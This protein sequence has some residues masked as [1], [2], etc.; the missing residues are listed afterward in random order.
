MLDNESANIESN[1]LYFFN[2]TE[3]T[4]KK[5]LIEQ[6]VLKASGLVGELFD[7]FHAI[8]YEKENIHVSPEDKKRLKDQYV[9]HSL[10]GHI[11]NTQKNFQTEWTR[12]ANVIG[13]VDGL[14][15]ASAVMFYLFPDNWKYEASNMS[16]DFYVT[17]EFIANICYPL[18]LGYIAYQANKTAQLNAYKEKY[19]VTDAQIPQEVRDRIETESK[20]LGLKVMAA[21]AGWT[22]GYEVAAKIWMSFN[23]QWLVFADA[24]GSTHGLVI[25]SALLIGLTAAL[26]LCVMALAVMVN[27][28][29]KDKKYSNGEDYAP[30]MQGIADAIMNVLKNDSLDLLKLF[31]IAFSAGAAWQILNSYSYGFVEK[32]EATNNGLLHFLAKCLEATIKGTATGLAVRSIFMLYRKDQT[33]QEVTKMTKFNRWAPVGSV[34][35]NK[36]H[37]ERADREMQEFPEMQGTGTQT[38]TSTMVARIAS[39]K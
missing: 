31:V 9:Q 23:P 8:V 12:T 3:T 18:L 33:D 17:P 34:D 38:S 5:L 30:G 39:A 10:E 37:K 4:Y 19:G 11:K 22:V 27:N 6:N 20:Q 29:L 25:A 7:K 1:T 36:I 24:S 35:P 28:E 14:W 13:L 2:I 32:A 16:G 26:F 15:A 21:V